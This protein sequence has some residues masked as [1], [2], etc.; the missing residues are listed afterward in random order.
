MAIRR[1]RKD[2]PGIQ[3]T[4]RTPGEFLALLAKRAQK[5]SLEVN[6]LSDD[7]VRAILNG[8]VNFTG[9]HFGV[10]YAMNTSDFPRR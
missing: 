3:C 1:K 9:V 6:A 7:Q 8:F 10:D 5:Y 2:F 4:W